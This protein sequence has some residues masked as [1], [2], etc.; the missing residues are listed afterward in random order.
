MKS[1]DDCV[2][3]LRPLKPDKRKLLLFAV[4][5]NDSARAGGTHW[6]LLVY[7]RDEGTFFNF[8][9]LSDFNTSNARKIFTTLKNLL[10]C[11]FGNFKHE[12]SAQQTNSYDCGIYLLVNAE[13]VCNNFLL[14]RRVQDTPIASLGS[15]NAKRQEILSI[16]DEINSN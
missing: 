15:I 3:V 8:D 1:P 16:I 7:S 11:P 4:N 6:S 5:D 14:R 9:S 10:N 13:N 2:E 12:R